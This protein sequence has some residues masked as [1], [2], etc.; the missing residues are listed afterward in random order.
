[1]ANSFSV[2]HSPDLI[3]RRRSLV[4]P[5]DVKEARLSLTVSCLI[6]FQIA[7][8]DESNSVIADGTSA[9]QELMADGKRFNSVSTL[10]F[11]ARAEHDGANFTCQAQNSANRQPRSASIG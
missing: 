4:T 3:P 10:R 6:R 9:V 2:K 5:T 11:T 7:W 1:M 8:L